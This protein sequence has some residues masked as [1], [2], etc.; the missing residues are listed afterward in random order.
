MQKI[1]LILSNLSSNVYN[2]ANY[3]STIY[4][5][6]KMSQQYFFFILALIFVLLAIVEINACS[7]GK[8]E[9]EKAMDRANQIVKDIKDRYD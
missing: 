1:F 8:S 2:F 4:F 9:A 6:L 7:G 5:R 3:H